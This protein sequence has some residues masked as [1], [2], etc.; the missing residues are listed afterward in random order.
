VSDAQNNNHRA[1]SVDSKRTATDFSFAP[2]NDDGTDAEKPLRPMPSWI[3]YG[4]RQINRAKYHIGEGFLEVG[5]FVMLIGP[6]YAG[7]STLV[8][9]L[10][11]YLAIGRSWL[12]FKAERTLRLMVVQ[13][14][15]AENKLI[16][17]GQMFKRM[18]LTQSQIKTAS[19]NTAILTI[20]DLQDSSAIKEIERHALVFK[21]DIL[22]INPMTSYLS[23]SVY[24]DE[25]I[26][27]FLRV[28]LTPMLDRLN[29]SAIVVHHPPKPVLNSKEPKDLTAFE[30][31][32]GGAG[33]AALT[34]AP[35]GNMFLV[36]TDGDVFKL[37]VGKGFE[38]LGT[39]E[40]TVFLRRSKDE[41]GIML[42]EECDQQA[43]QAA[44]EKQQTRKQTKRQTHFVPY[45]R[46]LK[47]LKPTQKYS[48]DKIVELA[49]K[50]LNMG[51]DR[52]KTAIRLL[53]AEKK[54]AKSEEKNPNGQAFVFYH[55]PTILEPAGEN[56]EHFQ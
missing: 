37:S 26:N 44:T 17:M 30:F 52:V 28:E 42:W 31:Q 14:E 45:D 5:S 1:A 47:V 20:R 34:N 22:I 23:G 21:P 6:S 4:T 32:Y 24:K 10:S 38:D 7:K 56:G 33:M 9:Q 27:R 11:I 50:E 3:D 16:R 2:L 48:P 19:E 18:G 51:R 46:L 39:K 55:L 40:T 8:A 36:H 43:A 53:A 15:D 49:K 54:L 13:A 25:V 35:R 12:F 41:D 29:M